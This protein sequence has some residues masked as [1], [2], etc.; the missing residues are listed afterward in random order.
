MCENMNETGVEYH[1]RMQAYRPTFLFTPKPSFYYCQSR[2]VIKIHYKFNPT[3]TV[4]LT[5][6]SLPLTY[7]NLVKWHDFYIQS[8]RCW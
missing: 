6:V 8:E 7:I 4:W 2:P 1:A 5:L 3:L